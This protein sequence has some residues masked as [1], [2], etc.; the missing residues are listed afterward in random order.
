MNI[1]KKYL[2]RETEPLN[3]IESQLQGHVFHVTRLAYLPSIVECGEIRPNGDG[4]LPTTFGFSE[5]GF[6]RK[7]N[8]V[9][10]FD[11]R[12]EPTEEI[13]DC[14][15]R[16]Y[17][18]RPASPPNGPI[19]ILILQPSAYDDLIPWSKWKEKSDFSEM[20]VPHIEVGYPGPLPLRLVGEIISVEITEEPQSHAALLRKAWSSKHG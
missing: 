12:S 9:S 11:Y 8:C 7:H 18:F 5:N 3:D 6:F 19:A 2:R 4:T 20:I 17:P 13:E 10:L 16:C 1:T 14:R 15:R